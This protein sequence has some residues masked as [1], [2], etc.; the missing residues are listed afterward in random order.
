[1]QLCNSKLLNKMGNLPGDIFF[2]SL[3][4]KGALTFCNKAFN[5]PHVDG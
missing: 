3:H 5:L 1:M 2:C 4:R